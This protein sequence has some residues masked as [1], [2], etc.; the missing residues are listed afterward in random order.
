MEGGGA[1]FG[2][3][4][5]FRFPF[6]RQAFPPLPPAFLTSSLSR[7]NIVVMGDADDDGRKY[8]DA[9]TN[10]PGEPVDSDSR[11][12]GDGGRGYRAIRFDRQRQHRRSTDDATTTTTTATTTAASD[13]PSIAAGRQQQQ[14]RRKRRKRRRDRRR[15]PRRR[16]R[17]EGRVGE[18]TVLPPDEATEAEAVRAEAPPIPLRKGRGPRTP[19][20]PTRVRTHAVQ[21]SRDHERTAFD[22]EFRFPIRG[23]GA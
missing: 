11:D 8:I 12:D 6:H 22:M 9:P 7:P 10:A 13:G 5:H 2:R 18:A 23:T 3:C 4:C 14:W 21:I 15:R 16:R 19:K 17:R 1:S 20:T